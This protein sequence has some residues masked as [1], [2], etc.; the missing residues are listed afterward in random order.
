M[1]EYH[2]TTAHTYSVANRNAHAKFDAIFLTNINIVAVARS[3]DNPICVAIGNI[4]ISDSQPK[5]IAVIARRL[6]R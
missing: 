6:I 3:I 4:R 5:H 2:S 1:G